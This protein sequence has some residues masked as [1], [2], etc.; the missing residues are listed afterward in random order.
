L[1]FGT[2]K[3][4]DADMAVKLNLR[5]ARRRRIHAYKREPIDLERSLIDARIR[6]K[7][8]IREAEGRIKQIDKALATLKAEPEFHALLKRVMETFLNN[9]W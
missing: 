2:D 8:A 1:L 4:H 5:N 9:R 6:L 3:G 7:R